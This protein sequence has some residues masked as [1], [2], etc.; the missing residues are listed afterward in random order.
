MSYKKGSRYR[1]L[2]I[3][4]NQLAVNQTQDLPSVMSIIDADETFA[5]YHLWL[6]E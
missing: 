2:L 1:Q 3:Y 6:L 4:S 5:V